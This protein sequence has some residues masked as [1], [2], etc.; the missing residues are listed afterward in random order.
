MEKSH[1]FSFT[2][3]KKPEFRPN[4]KLTYLIYQSEWTQEGKKHYQGY[5]ETVNP[6]TI[7]QI[8]SILKDKTV[9]VEIAHQSRSANT[10]YCTKI[11][12]F[13]GYRYMNDYI[14]NE[15]HIIDMLPFDLTELPDKPVEAKSPISQWIDDYF[16]QINAPEKTEK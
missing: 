12:T 1:R 2:S 4:C 15:E 10:F 8:K 3:W 6:Y 7:L 11:K 14:N 13:A 9:H 16:N 5:V